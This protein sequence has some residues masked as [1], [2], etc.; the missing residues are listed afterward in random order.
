MAR[1]IDGDDDMSRR[2]A[3]LL[4]LPT[5]RQHCSAGPPPA[6]HGETRVFRVACDVV[7]GEAIP[8]QRAFNAGEGSNPNTFLLGGTFAMRTANVF[9]TQREHL[10][11]MLTSILGSLE[12]EC[13]MLSVI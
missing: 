2:L 9:G 3:P 4:V 6:K 11:F 1:S 13:G 8:N 5:A 10:Q 7:R 12:M